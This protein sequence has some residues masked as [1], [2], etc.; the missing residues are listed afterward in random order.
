LLELPSRVLSGPVVGV[1]RAF[2]SHPFGRATTF[3]YGPWPHG[4]M[5]TSAYPA[6][7]LPSR[8]HGG[9]LGS[10]G[11]DF[12]LLA[13]AATARTHAAAVSST[14][15]AVAVVIWSGYA[16]WWE[17][18]GAALGRFCA[19]VAVGGTGGGAATHGGGRGRP[20][21]HAARCHRPAVRRCPL[22]LAG[23]AG[24]RGPF[25]PGVWFWWEVARSNRRGPPVLGPPKPRQKAVPLPAS[26]D[27][28]SIQY[29]PFK[30]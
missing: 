30:T 18:P 11:G 2:L 28:P 5:P 20:A 1:E 6:H 27:T 7:T 14:P 10:L 19:S 13:Q 15:A 23:H 26:G 21:G 29:R 22:P 12:L 3:R 9:S 4:G 16:I 8:W 24:P 25:S 17:H